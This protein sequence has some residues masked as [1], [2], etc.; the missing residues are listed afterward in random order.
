MAGINGGGMVSVGDGLAGSGAGRLLYVVNDAPFF[1]SHRLP[2]AIGAREAG[3]TVT[4]A[5]PAHPAQREIEAAGLAFRPIPLSRSGAAPR[6][7]LR[8]LLALVRLYRNLRPDLVH[9][10]THKPILYGSLAA[11]VTGVSAVVNA[12]PGLGYLFVAEGVKARLR[13]RTVLAAYRLAFGH[14][15]A[16]GIFQNTEDRDLFL[17]ARVIRPDQVAVIRGAGVDLRQ[18]RPEPEPLGPPLVVLASRLLWDKGVGEFVEAVGRLRSRGVR[19]RA[20][21]V[22]EPDP[23]NPRAIAVAQ[24][25]R[26]R[27]SGVV[28]WWG[29]RPDM[30]A[31]LAGCHLVCLP[32]YYREGVPK[33][34]IEAAASGRAIVT[35]D[36]PGCRDVVR[37]GQNGLLVPPRDVPALAAALEALLADP[38]RRASMGQCGREIAE[39]EFGL[40]GVVEST[41][42]LY[43][44]L[45]N[46]VARRAS[47]HPA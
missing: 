22:G 28:E 5:T 40:A 14:P 44:E 45:L 15:M 4:V 38:S 27:D 25:E 41:L 26:W 6:A 31:V 35:T 18:F 7:E 23:G 37:H 19:F 39:A 12:V 13:R 42:A 10:V 32:S 1:L 33:V 21:L 9:Q 47:T 29:F 2:V 43:R 46:R 36:V 17:S 8:S 3:Y 11:R 30:P 16:M 24:L 34:L 20:A